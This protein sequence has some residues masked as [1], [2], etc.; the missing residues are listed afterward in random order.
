MTLTIG[1][2]GCGQLGG[3]IGRAL[4]RTGFVRPEQLWIANR[5]GDRAAFADWPGLHWTGELQELG[6]R[7]ALI[8]LALPPAAARTVRLTAPDRLVVSV[9]AGVG[10]AQ[11]QDLA[12]TA[13][14]VRA[15]SSPAAELGLAYSPWYAAPGVGAEDKALVRRLFAACGVTDEVPEEAQLDIFTAITGPVPGFVALF[16]ESMRAYAVRQGVAPAV[17]ERAV[18]QLF[19]AGGQMLAASELS[20]EEQVR[21]MIDYAGTTAAGMLQM[22]ASGLEAA[23]DAGL[24]AARRRSATIAG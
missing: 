8:L 20:P 11:L 14:V 16:A 12:G 17:A 6:D 19:L 10:V 23:I 15:M 18:R 1:L 5:S 13:R 24:E 9:M 2:A 7:C 21:A 22:R 3:A 4:L